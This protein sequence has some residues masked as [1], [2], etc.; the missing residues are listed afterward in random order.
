MRG[1]R[2]G[3]RYVRLVRPRLSRQFKLQAP[4]YLVATERV[5]RPTGLVGSAFD[6]ARRVLIGR[7]IPTEQ[8]AATTETAAA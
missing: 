1:G 4:G 3:T 2:P 5:L 8:P 7:R 6:V